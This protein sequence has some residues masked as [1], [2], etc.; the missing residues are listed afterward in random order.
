MHKEKENSR[1]WGRARGGVAP[2]FSR[3][4]RNPP[5][6]AKGLWSWAPPQPREAAAGRAARADAKPASPPPHPG[7]GPRHSHLRSASPPLPAGPPLCCCCCCSEPASPNSLG[8]SGK[9]L[10]KCPRTRDKRAA[11]EPALLPDRP[12]SLLPRLGQLSR[13][14][15]A[16]PTPTAFQPIAPKASRAP[17][18]RSP[19][20]FTPRGSAPRRHSFY[21]EHPI[22]CQL[23]EAL[24]QI[25]N[26]TQRALE[27]KTTIPRMPRASLR[28]SIL[29]SPPHARGALGCVG[30]SHSDDPIRPQKP[31]ATLGV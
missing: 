16:E 24:L 21:S 14:C 25:S 13:T 28:L 4:K 7:L 31:R 20:P 29:M 27:Q 3:L 26:Q 23:G 6:V 1:G 15:T 18:A 30:P 22:R 8:P 10:K 2:N 19:A 11:E 5:G 9:I 17:P 12:W